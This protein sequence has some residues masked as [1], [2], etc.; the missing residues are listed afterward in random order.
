[1]AALKGKSDIG[2]QIKQGMMLDLLTGKV[3]TV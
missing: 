2:G 1:M 3:R